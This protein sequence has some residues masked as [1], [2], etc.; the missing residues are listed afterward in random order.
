MHPFP[1]ARVQAIMRA[2]A[3]DMVADAQLFRSLDVGLQNSVIRHGREFQRGI[4]LRGAVETRGAVED[5]QVAILDLGLE[6]AAGAHAQEDFSAH[7]RQ[8]FH[9]NGRGGAADAGA[10]AGDGHAL[11]ST[12]IADILTVVGYLF[13]GIPGGSDGFHAAGITR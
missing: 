9:G 11:I 12:A 1:D 5:D 13:P 8:L 10:G 2:R 7:T 6:G 4:G 3:T